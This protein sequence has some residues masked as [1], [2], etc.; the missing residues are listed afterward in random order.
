M[1]R[2]SFQNSPYTR[3]LHEP[4]QLPVADQPLS[5]RRLHSFAAQQPELYK[6]LIVTP[7]GEGRPK[8]T[9]AE[10]RQQFIVLSTAIAQ[11]DG[12]LDKN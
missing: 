5:F 3:M 2:H 10:W 12:F 4:D 6:R 11:S 1:I 9:A 8:A 7:G